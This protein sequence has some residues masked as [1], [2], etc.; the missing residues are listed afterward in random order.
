MRAEKG[1]GAAIRV[2]M[3]CDVCGQ[4]MESRT[5]TRE[6]AYHY[7][8]SG[9]DNVFLVGITV[10]ACQHC[11]IEI[12]EIPHVEELNQTIAEALANKA[13]LLTGPEIR[14]LRNRAGFSAKKF[15]ALLN[16]TPEHLSRIENSDS[17]GMGGAA[18]KLARVATM[19]GEQVREFLFRLSEMH[20]KKDEQP[21]VVEFVRPGK[22][23]QWRKIEGEVAA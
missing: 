10:Y 11:D 19:D 8:L 18:D 16:V 21:K 7:D 14:F 4:D 22:N 15:A 3:Q 5:A 12:P 23:K 1:A 9:L 2:A 17:Q 20:L 6:N 13:T